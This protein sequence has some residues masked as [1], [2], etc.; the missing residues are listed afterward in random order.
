ME[1]RAFHVSACFSLK[2]TIFTD[3]VTAV[4]GSCCKRPLNQCIM[5]RVHFSISQF[6]VVVICVLW[7]TSQTVRNCGAWLLAWCC[8]DFSDWIFPMASDLW[9]FCF[10]S[11][12]AIWDVLG[13]IMVVQA[14]DAC[15]WSFSQI[16]CYDESRPLTVGSLL[17][18][19]V[20]RLLRYCHAMF[21]ASFRIRVF[22]D[23]E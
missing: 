15:W 4:L 9:C 10:W 16:Y 5:L 8:T 23:C 19:C 11:V 6:A 12:E 21:T 17:S 22:R 1:N 14:F 7:L 20:L 18:V 13:G 2:T 3:N